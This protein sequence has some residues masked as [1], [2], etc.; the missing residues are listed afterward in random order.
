M[1]KMLL[2]LLLLPIVHVVAVAMVAEGCTV[3]VPVRRVCSRSRSRHGWSPCRLV[4]VARQ[5]LVLVLV[6]VTTIL[7]PAVRWHL[8]L[9]HLAQLIFALAMMTMTIT[10]MMM[11]M[12]MMTTARWYMHRR[13]RRQVQPAVVPGEEEPTCCVRVRV[14]RRR[15][16]LWTAGICR[17][18]CRRRRPIGRQVDLRPVL[19]L[20]L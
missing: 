10:T 20:F 5:V 9:L 7:A 15:P 8:L 18:G 14:V 3:R 12:M 16:L 4:H 13:G 17:C 1:V 19:V 2:V 11:M 6:L